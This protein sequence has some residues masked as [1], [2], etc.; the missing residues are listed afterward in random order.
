MSSNRKP[1]KILGIARALY[2]IGSASLNF[3]LGQ[4][5]YPVSQ[6]A[7]NEL[8]VE[9]TSNYKNGILGI[10]HSGDMPQPVLEDVAS[11]LDNKY[12]DLIKNAGLFLPKPVFEEG[13]VGYNK[14]AVVYT[15][16]EDNTIT[17]YISQVDNNKSTDLTDTNYWVKEATIPGIIDGSKLVLNNL[18]D[19]A[20]ENI[21]DIINLD[22][23]DFSLLKTSLDNI[24]PT[25]NKELNGDTITSATIVVPERIKYL[26][27]KLTP[28][29]DFTIVNG[30]PSVDLKGCYLISMAQRNLI[31]STYN[32]DCK[33]Y[34]YIEGSDTLILPT[35]KDI[36]NQLNKNK[37]DLDGS[38]A[39]FN[40]L[41]DIAKNNIK[42]L[43]KNVNIG[44]LS[45][46]TRMDVP[47]GWLRC[48]G[49][50]YTKDEFPDFWNDYLTKSKIP[51][52][53]YT[54]YSYEINHFGNC[55]KFAVD[56]VNLTF[57]V[58]TIQGQVFISQA[59]ASG[60][61][62]QFNAESLPNIKGSFTNENSGTAEGCFYKAGNDRLNGRSGN[63]NYNITYYFDASRSSL[64]YK[65][66]AKV[67][68]NN[69]QFPI[70][71]YITNVQVPVSEAQY[72]G[73]ISNLNQKVDLNGS[74]ATFSNL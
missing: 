20:K 16:N 46:F 14:N 41:S 19:T 30:E 2:K 4:A 39:T 54:D 44:Q 21:K 47:S 28:A 48:D 40:N 58:P 5:T 61:I 35:V 34:T 72:N 53:S 66:G 74:K 33:Y 59:L 56:L 29:P 55:G 11:H 73:F 23:S 38:N 63:D 49:T 8:D 50:Q 51:I 45:F 26:K 31:T 36:F 10:T 9:N 69:I 25:N 6:I 24:V 3:V 1:Y 43:N 70:F 65:N 68:P 60:D 52:G 13:E 27:T 37:V 57:K 12:E 22:S 64:V 7:T 15:Q 18:S 32:G 67:Q 62:A 17:F 71:V 42:Q